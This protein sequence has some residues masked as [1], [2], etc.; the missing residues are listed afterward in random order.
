MLSEYLFNLFTR[1]K[2]GLLQKALKSVVSLL[3]VTSKS[4]S[5][6]FKAKMVPIH[7]MKEDGN[8]SYWEHTNENQ[9]RRTS[10]ILNNFAFGA[11][12]GTLLYILPVLGH[13]IHNFG[14]QTGTTYVYDSFFRPCISK[15]ETDIDRNLMELRTRAGDISVSYWQ[16]A[17][18]YRQTRVFDV[19]RYISSQ[20]TPKPR[21]SQGRGS[22]AIDN[23]SNGKTVSNHNQLK[24]THPSGNDL[25]NFGSS[26]N[27]WVVQQGPIQVTFW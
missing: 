3:L 6:R 5:S 16:R 23:L 18:S 25:S 22:Q 17:A 14:S 21:L 11:N 10:P 20:S 15:H 19:L 26:G 7:V 8:R 1:S 2:L 27:G 9:W 24:V 13:F 12:I 4:F